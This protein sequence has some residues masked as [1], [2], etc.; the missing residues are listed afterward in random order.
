MARI[1]IV[2]DEQMERALLQTVLEQAGHEVF[3]A[4]NGL[5]AIDVY[6]R[7]P[8]DLVITDIDMPESNGLQLIHELREERRDLP[9][10]AVSGSAPVLLPLAKECGADTVLTKPLDLQKFAVAVEQALDS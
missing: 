4:G 3:L 2:D 8:V 7:N 5:A 10:V 9:I 6:R 1:L